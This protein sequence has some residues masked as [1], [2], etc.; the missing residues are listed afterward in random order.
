ML[1]PLADI[2]KRPVVFVDAAGAGAP[3]AG[4]SQQVA[5]QLI[6]DLYRAF[7][8]HY[9][10]TSNVVTGR[11]REE[12]VSQLEQCGLPLV[13]RNLHQDWATPCNRDSNLAEE[14]EAWHSTSADRTPTSYVVIA[15]AER[16]ASL[17]G[18]GLAEYAV[19]FDDV[20]TEADYKKACQILHSQ[21][22]FEPINTDWY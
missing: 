18:D 21:L 15:P 17:Q 5:S 16:G 2:N 6:A 11:S 12:I 14:I 4:A 10:L 1:G 8:A 19:L 7:D 13:A 22:S 20:F 3:Q 9:V